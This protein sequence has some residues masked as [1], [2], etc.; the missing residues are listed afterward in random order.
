[1]QIL[2]AIRGS[3]AELSQNNRMASDA[4]ADRSVRVRFEPDV[5]TKSGR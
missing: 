2:R 1:V 3:C 4:G 5:R